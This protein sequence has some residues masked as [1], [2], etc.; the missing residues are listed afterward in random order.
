MYI[1]HMYY[2]AY[3]GIHRIKYIYMGSLLLRK[4]WTCP[5]QATVQKRLIKVAIPISTK[6]RSR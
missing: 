5:T 6:Y 1:V 4:T 3:V 2:I